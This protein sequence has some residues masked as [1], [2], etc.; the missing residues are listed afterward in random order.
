MK[1]KINKWLCPPGYTIILFGTIYVRDLEHY[2]QLIQPNNYIYNHEHIH[3]KQAANN[4]IWFYIKYILFYLKHIYWLIYNINAP[5]YFHP[6]EI[7]A[8]KNQYDLNYVFKVN[9]DK[10]YKKYTKIPTKVIKKFYRDK[11]N[12]YNFISKL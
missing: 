1:I 11:L 12:Y 4:W 3:K 10:E 9:A 5:Y 8:Y 7:E 2:L 6:M